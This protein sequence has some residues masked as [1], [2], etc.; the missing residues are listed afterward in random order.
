MVRNT[1]A[2]SLMA[3]IERR[4]RAT[5]ESAD[6]ASLRAAGSQ[7]AAQLGWLPGTSSSSVFALRCSALE[8]SLKTIFAGIDAA[9]A[10]SPNSDD[11]RWL[12][13]NVQL[14]FSEM[15]AVGYELKPLKRLPHARD[16]HGVVMPRVLA[17][18]AAFLEA[19]SDRFW[20]AG[21]MAFAEGFQEHTVL[22]LCEITTLAPALKLALLERIAER[23]N[24]I[25]NDDTVAAVN[26]GI[27][28]RGLR[29]VAQTS[30]R[31]VVE[32][33][34]LFDKVLRQDP[35]ESYA[36]MD[37]ESRN[38]YRIKVSKI[39]RHSDLD[40]TEVAR[41]ALA[42]ARQARAR[43]YRDARVKLRESH[44]GYYLIGKGR[45]VLAE[46]V[47]YS[48]GFW[49]KLRLLLLRHPDE[50]FLPGIAILTFAI[51][52]G[53]L[54]LLTSPTSSPE[55]VLLSMLI[56]L[57]PS[58]QAAVQVMT[59][60]VV[61]VLP[62]EILPKLDFSD[63]VPN[64][65][66]TLVAIPTLLL[67]EKQVRGLIES[68][69][70]RY[71]GNHDPNVHFALVSDLSDSDQP[72]PE[73]NPLIDLCSRL[74]GDLNE[75]YGEGNGS[76][77]L[78]HR[79]RVYNPREKGWMGWER[80]RGKLLDL[81]KLLR[82]QYDSFPIKVGD[83]SILPK[84]RFVITLDSDTELPRGSAQRMVGTLAHPLNQAIID[85]ESN[86]VVTGYGI[87][88]P[89][90]GVSVQSTARSRLATIYAGET[91]F[92]IYTRAVSDTYQDLYGEG[93]FTGKGIYEVDALHRVLDRRFPRN[94]LL[95][96]DLIEG[97]YAR[98]GLASDIEVIEDY[99]SHYS[100]YN[101][102]KHRWLRG[103]WQIVEWLTSRVP[104]ESGN[105]VPNPISLIS[106]WKIFDNL[107]RSLVE[108][109]TMLLLL[110]GWLVP[111]QN[112]LR[113]TLVAICILF[114]PSWFEFGF[115]L[116]RALAE[117][118]LDFA[119]NALTTLYAATV[120]VG[121]TL[122][123][124][125]HQTMLSLDAVV[126]ALVRRVFTRQRLLEWETAAEAEIGD[127]RTPIDRYL[128][129]MPVLSCVIG[130]FLWWVRPKSLVAAVPI[131]LLWASSKLV[132]LWLNESPLPPNRQLNAQDA[133]LLRR[134][135]LFTWRYFAEFSTAEHN[136]L[137]PD[138]VQED[139]AAIADRVSP[140][141]LGLLLNAR[142]VAVE[143]GYLTA[144][145]LA[146]LTQLTL[147]TVDQLPKYRGHLLN[148]YDTRTL[149]PL[150]P[151]FV[152]SVDSGNFLASLWTL[153]QG[154]LDRMRKPLVERSLAEGLL[155]HIR[156][157]A[158]WHALPQK[159]LA[160]WERLLSGENWLQSALE[161]PESRFDAIQAREKSKHA[162]D[163]RW[164]RD[165]A[166]SRL[167]N[168]RQVVNDYVPW[169]LPEFAAL[170]SEKPF[171]DRLA[172]DV[173]LQQLPD[174]TWELEAL[175]NELAGASAEARAL[176]QRL[177]PRLAEARANALRL[178]DDLRTISSE[179]GTLANDMDFGFL[180]DKRRELLSVGF[181]ART[182]QLQASCY[183]LL[184]TE[185][186]T[187][188]FTAI[189]KEDIPQECWFRLGRAHTL[190]HGRPILMSWT[191][192]M[193]EYLM[194]TLWMRSYPNTLLDRTQIAVVRS[195]QAYAATR[196]IPWGISESAYFKLDEAGNYQYRAFGL[197]H[198]ALMRQDTKAL[199]ISP[200]STFLALDV[201]RAASLQNLRRMEGL[202]WVGSYGF[203]ESADYTIFRSRFRWTRCEVVRCWMAHHQGMSLLAL[204]NLL[205]DRAVQS[206]FYSDRRVQATEL[207]LHEKP[208][209]RAKSADIPYGKAVA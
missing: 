157:L 196:G 198:L 61:A 16:Q 177:K 144:P 73:E 55:L 65:C 137:I 193:F 33:L 39:A 168:I 162:P 54:L 80:K 71:L 119:R 49:Q 174:L 63:G 203:Y 62:P 124:L 195:Q 156:T 208:V 205:C 185:S 23:G 12:R 56:V 178:C 120:N 69:E 161:I 84:V 122:V 14:V 172:D 182:G 112:H 134:Y 194:P 200:Y 188:V 164:L 20:E 17:L 75:K 42:L 207:L 46:R 1:Q 179:A 118:K 15:Q 59:Y 34:V 64:D 159:E 58:S 77:L 165:E 76:F 206:W 47:G 57:L 133:V 32:P 197:P 31:D 175:V 191:G 95:S 158:E 166:R 125:A 83:V 129:W 184:A 169:C 66:V 37:A 101:R 89:R 79:H 48:P 44:I 28:I 103:D 96:H 138:N 121:L 142:Q 113:W 135:A 189:A 141:N 116:I 25:L 6:L 10:F 186:R 81:N 127:R 110:F 35:A 88:Q 145:E 199:V 176:Y 22:E 53:I 151:E 167:N 109:A 163:V 104:V 8:K 30:W 131:L 18:A 92:D 149:A 155:D 106:R 107:R 41:E 9:F 171:S 74:I 204:A 136:W 100:A 29:D 2:E 160:R 50:F 183:D 98:A 152:S 154:C 132:A 128:D 93:S 40:E 202:G 3:D 82:G 192:T 187:A 114:I 209:A 108:P 117:Y 190:A 180:M 13:D 5:E 99:P 140:T 150:A 126:R 4:S 85:A 139:P 94:A 143:F 21:F 26:V 68:L 86:I 130:L 78:L 52:T 24:L 90:V 201:D 72:A 7:F 67:N 97:A 173:S 123:F 146:R 102:R 27:C 115:S 91:G 147:A 181:D 60:L 87:L 170:R 45:E 36:A 105:H 38:L 70:V 19:A 43:S 111:R 11:L 153:E 51:V 148:W